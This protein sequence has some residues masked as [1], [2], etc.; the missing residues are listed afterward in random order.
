M[1]ESAFPLNV[2]YVKS[3]PIVCVSEFVQYSF[4]TEY[5]SHLILHNSK[6]ITVFLFQLS[7]FPI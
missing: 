5:V 6:L 3:Y 4:S 7:M 1:D 2:D